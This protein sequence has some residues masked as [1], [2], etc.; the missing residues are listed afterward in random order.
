MSDYG[1]YVAI[2]RFVARK[3]DRSDARIAAMMDNL[4][5]AAAEIEAQ[6]GFD[7][8]ADHLELTARAF[9]GVAGFLQKQILPEAVAEGN[10]TGEAQIRWAIDNSMEAVNSLLGRAALTEQRSDMRITLPAPPAA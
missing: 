2:L 9:A 8:V 7:V 5:R 6:G 1:F 3:S 4:E 10:K